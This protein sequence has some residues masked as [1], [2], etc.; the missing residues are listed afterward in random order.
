[1]Q[2]PRAQPG[3]DTTSTYFQ[4]DEPDE[5]V[6]RDDRGRPIPV[7]AEQQATGEPAS[8]AAAAR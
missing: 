8:D 4:L 2:I 5:P 7:S 6:A 1:M 3:L